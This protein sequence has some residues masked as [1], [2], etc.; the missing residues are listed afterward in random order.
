MYDCTREFGSL[1][2]LTLV[3]AHD[4]YIALAKL[5]PNLESLYLH[6]CGQL[7]TESV[8]T[9]GESLKHLKRLELF[10]PFL[11]RQQ[12]WM[13]FFK[14]V[15][16]RLEGFLVTQSPRIDLE[17]IE[18][19]VTHCRN[20]TQLR[21]AE[22][23]QL[24]DDLIVPLAQL[25]KLHLLDLSAPGTPLTDDG[26]IALLSQVG[27]HLISLNLSDNPDLTDAIL[28]SIVKYCPNLRRLS[29]R[30]VVEL[31]D[32]GVSAFFISLK[33][34]QRPGLEIIDL[35]KGHDLQ[36]G[37]LRALVE[38][39]GDTIEH[40]N[41]LGWRE[42]DAESIGELAKCSQ[43]RELDLG[44]CREVTDFTIKEILE[45]CGSIKLIRVWGEVLTFGLDSAHGDRLQSTYRRRP[46]QEGCQH[47]RHRNA[48]DL[49]RT[50]FC[51]V[52]SL[53]REHRIFRILILV[54][55]RRHG[56]MSRIQCYLDFLI[57]DPYALVTY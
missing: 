45:S 54:Q 31:T 16:D 49:S 12:G 39:S 43:L 7:A 20:L 57:L 3:L 15:G 8:I 23:G 17:T 33:S 55:L 6:L 38:H 18:T 22:V 5:C 25:K 26:V 56:M 47:H 40:L 10:G 29:L 41:I 53:P 11:V 37:S 36:G 21:L 52:H 44:W 46:A 1:A 35:E 50:A 30:N 32:E 4:A 9:L 34:L 14:S 51:V 19:L 48:Y 2:P 27:E 13:S 28:P 42:A 24:K